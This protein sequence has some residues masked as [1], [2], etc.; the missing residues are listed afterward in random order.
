MENLSDAEVILSA[1]GGDDDNP[2]VSSGKRYKSNTIYGDDASI[3]N[4]NSQNIKNLL[5]SH[6]DSL[7]KPWKGSIKFKCF[8]MNKHARDISKLLLGQPQEIDICDYLCGQFPTAKRLY[9]DSNRYPPPLGKRIMS[10]RR[11]KR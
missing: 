1:D 2:D 4:M 10:G 6:V 11:C 7:S 5:D 8:V 9:F 3:A